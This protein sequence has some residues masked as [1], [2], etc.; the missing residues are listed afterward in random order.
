MIAADVPGGSGVSTATTLY[1]KVHGV[2]SRGRGARRRRGVLL[3]AMSSLGQDLFLPLSG[4]PQPVAGSE[5]FMPH[6]PRFFDNLLRQSH[7]P[8]CRP[9]MSISRPR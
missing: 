6:P 9:A 1:Q 2:S 5:G 8:G 3:P 4:Q 7:W